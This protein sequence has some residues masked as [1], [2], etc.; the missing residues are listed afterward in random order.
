MLK[1]QPKPKTCQNCY[2]SGKV[3]TKDKKQERCPLC[4]GSGKTVARG[5]YL[6]K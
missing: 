4:N 3:L 5:G 1:P 6:T 2:G